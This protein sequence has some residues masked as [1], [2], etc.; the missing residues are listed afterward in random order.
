VV[1]ISLAGAKRRRRS[2][3]NDAG[4]AGPRDNPA[5]I[6]VLG[7][8][9]KPDWGTKCIENSQRIEELCEA[10]GSRDT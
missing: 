3:E 10:N 1:D 2:N 6:K 4:N 5:G 8:K 7:I 9:E